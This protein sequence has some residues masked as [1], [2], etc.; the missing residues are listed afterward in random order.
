MPIFKGILKLQTA[1]FGWSELHWLVPDNFTDAVVG[2]KAIA[3]AR[4]P[5]S[6]ADVVLKDAVVIDAET[7]RTA[8]HPSLATWAAAGTWA[9]GTTV[10]PNL[11]IMFRMEDAAHEHRSRNYIRGFPS[12]QFATGTGGPDCNFTFTAPYQA[13][14]DAYKVA[15]IANVNL[16]H[17]TAPHTFTIFPVNSCFE[18]L[19]SRLRRAGRPFLL[20]H[21]RR[22]IA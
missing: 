16:V 1:D 4:M 12:D 6:K 7:P 8:L 17:K 2:L 10:T 11:S 5:L 14:I 19:T 22:L 20:P 15:I 21:G 13:L 3:A 9:T 18:T